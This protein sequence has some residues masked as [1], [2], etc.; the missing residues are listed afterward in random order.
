ME[1]QANS[2]SLIHPWGSWNNI[3]S[4]NTKILVG[5]WINHYYLGKPQ[6]RSNKE[7]QRLF[8]QLPP[9][10]MLLLWCL[11]SFPLWRMVL[12]LIPPS[13]LVSPSVNI[14]VMSSHRGAPTTVF[15]GWCSFTQVLASVGKVI[16]SHWRM[17]TSVL[18]SGEL[19]L[20]PQGRVL[21]GLLHFLMRKLPES[22]TGGFTTAQVSSTLR[23]PG[24]KQHQNPESG[25]FYSLGS[26][27]TPPILAS[28]CLLS[29]QLEAPS[30]YSQSPRW[31]ENINV[32]EKI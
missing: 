7:L 8:T 28:I 22:L 30:I 5:G 16:R 9:Q 12:F 10:Q 31:A 11:H 27:G 25:Q 14:S 4:H 21:T 24:N 20:R 6:A 18:L 26:Q 1:N 32:S 2:P 13:S 3:H 29:K 17:M 19:W 23:N 15:F